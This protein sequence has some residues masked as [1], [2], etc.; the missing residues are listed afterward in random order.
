M[1]ELNKLPMDT[2][3]EL[4]RQRILAE[5]N[6]DSITISKLIFQ[7]PDL[8]SI[9]FEDFIFNFRMSIESIRQKYGEDFTKLVEPREIIFH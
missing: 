4:Y 9:E 3:M 7:H 5:R 8:F 1:K 6:G 2:V